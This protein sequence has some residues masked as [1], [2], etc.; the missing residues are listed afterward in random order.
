MD[1]GALSLNRTSV[2]LKHTGAPGPSSAAGGASI[3]P[4]W[5]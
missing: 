5:D 3:E 4:A 2:G 1:F